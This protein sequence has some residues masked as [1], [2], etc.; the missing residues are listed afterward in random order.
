MCHGCAEPSRHR[1]N[2]VIG[3][4]GGCQLLWEGDEGG[5]GVWGV[6]CLWKIWS[7]Q[8]CV[9]VCVCDIVEQVHCG[10]G[11]VR[12]QGAKAG[13]CWV[14]LPA[15]LLTS[16]RQLDLLSLFDSKDILP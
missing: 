16:R 13:S 8:V 7:A 5:G 4:P 15:G 9:C 12:A 11:E 6:S 14:L 1:A 10:Q 2:T 3:R